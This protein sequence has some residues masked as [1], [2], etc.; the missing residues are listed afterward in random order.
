EPIS[1]PKTPAK[2]GISR[3]T[4]L[5]GLAGIVVVA[6][7]DITWWILTS[8]SSSLYTYRGHSDTVDAV[9]WSPDGRRIASGSSDGTAQVWNAADWCHVYTYR[10]HSDGVVAVAWS[11]DGRRIASG[12][13]DGT[14]QVWNAAD[15]SNPY[16][17][18]GQSFDVDAV[19]WSPDGKRIA[20]G[21]SDG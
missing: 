17:Y 18:Q 19:A 11:P 21:S 8:H 13:S 7:G 3:R 6:G 1:P 9:A 15:G 2:G 16:T 5:V 12:S 14:A 20:S 10:G 4:L